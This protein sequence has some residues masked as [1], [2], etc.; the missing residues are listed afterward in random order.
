MKLPEIPKIK[1]TKKIK[2]YFTVS[3]V[4]T[5]LYQ[6]YETARDVTYIVPKW[7]VD[8][9]EEKL[10][11]YR[12]IGLPED[13]IK[14][15][16]DKSLFADDREE[17]LTMCEKEIVTFIP[18]DN[19]ICEKKLFFTN[20][21]SYEIISGS[22]EK[23]YKKLKIIVP[24]QSSTLFPEDDFISCFGKKIVREKRTEFINR[25]ESRW[26]C[27][28]F[29]LNEALRNSHEEDTFPHLY[30]EKDTLVECRETDKN[31]EYII[32]LDKIEVFDDFNKETSF[33]GGLNTED[34]EAIKASAQIHANA[35]TEVAEIKAESDFRTTKMKWLSDAGYV[36]ADSWY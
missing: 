16:M 29:T 24:P 17:D 5:F 10:S 13:E 1:K 12:K 2:Y 3:K 33:V 20:S 15:I 22:Y 26:V 4:R 30:G 7:Y 8:G 27:Q 18:S 34:N 23:A 25:I 32:K 31:E 11:H 28:N 14:R 36:P 6:E 19:L 21:K 9:K 35:M